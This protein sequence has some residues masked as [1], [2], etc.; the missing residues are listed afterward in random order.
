MAVVSITIT[1]I[2]ILKSP[3]LTAQSFGNTGYEYGRGVYGGYYSNCIVYYNTQFQKILLTLKASGVFPVVLP[4]FIVALRLL[5]SFGVE[6][7]PTN[8]SL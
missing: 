5:M 7:L 4:F 3:S 1:V 2:T 8:L 6:A